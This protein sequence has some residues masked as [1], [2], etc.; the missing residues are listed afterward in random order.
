MRASQGWPQRMDSRPSCETGISRPPQDEGRFQLSLA[1]YRA[2]LLHEPSILAN[3]CFGERTNF[4]RCISRPASKEW[5]LPGKR[6]DTIKVK[7][8]W[9]RQSYLA[10]VVSL[11]NNQINILPL[12]DFQNC[13]AV[14]DATSEIAC[15]LSLQN[16]SY[17]SRPQIRPGVGR[18]LILRIPAS[19]KRRTA[20]S[21]ARRMAARRGR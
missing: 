3:I 4:G 7:P 6:Y 18:G 15:F 11:L 5:R 12:C 13:G 21:I 20:V 16:V 1:L 9:P 10:E 2:S 19:D 8:S 17:Q 14:G